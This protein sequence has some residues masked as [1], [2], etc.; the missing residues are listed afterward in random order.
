MSV[1]AYLLQFAVFGI[2]VVTL[3]VLV[4]AWLHSLGVTWW[5]LPVGVGYTV[6]GLGREAWDW[7]RR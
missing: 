4:L 3:S 7:T 6:G 2:L 5:W 1:R